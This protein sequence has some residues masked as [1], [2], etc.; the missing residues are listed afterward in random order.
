MTL[1][2]IHQE[3]K[4]RRL[5]TCGDFNAGTGN[6]TKYDNERIIGKYGMDDENQRGQWMKQWATS[7]NMTIT[8]TFFLKHLAIVKRSLALTV[9][10]D[11]LT[12]V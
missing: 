3:C 12:T 2:A 6:R 1:T 9:A 7:M 10:H 8:N 11:N 5:I 4:G